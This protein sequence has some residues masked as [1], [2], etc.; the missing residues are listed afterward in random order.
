MYLEHHLICSHWDPSFLAEMK[1]RVWL[2]CHSWAI[3][4][5]VIPTSYNTW[6]FKY[7][8]GSRYK[9]ASLCQLNK[10]MSSPPQSFKESDMCAINER[11]II[12]C[13]HEHN[14]LCCEFCTGLCQTFNPVVIQ[15][16]EIISEVLYNIFLILSHQNLIR[17]TEVSWKIEFRKFTVRK[18]YLLKF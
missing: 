2:I 3:F 12:V 5:D 17:D 1:L 4:L 15:H 9:S 7:L 8:S 18:I 13:W 16:M 14:L 10:L 11:Q 6:P